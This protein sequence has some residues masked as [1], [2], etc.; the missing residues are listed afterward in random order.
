MG[1]KK[2]RGNGEGTVYQR[3]DGKW[4]AQVSLGNDPTTVKLKRR[5]FYGDSRPEVVKKM[6]EVLVELEKGIYIE[7]ATI[8]L[9]KWLTDWLESRKPLIAENTWNAYE[10][11]IRIHIAP[12]LGK[13]KLKDLK[14]RDIQKLLNEKLT[15]GRITLKGSKRNAPKKYS[16]N[17]GLSARSVKY[18]YQT[19]N[20]ALRQA[21]RERV[22]PFNPAEHC[23]LLRQQKKEMRVFT[24]EELAIF[25]KT[26]QEISPHFTAFYLNVTT[27]LRRGE[28]LGITWDCVD[29]KEG[30]IDVKQ[31]VTVSKENGPVLTG[32][33]TEKSRRKIKLDTDT[34]GLL[35]FH[36]RRQENIKKMLGPDYQDN[37]LVFATDD[38]RPINPR[39]FT[40]HFS[41]VLGKSGLSG[42]RLHDL[43]HLYATLALEAGVDLKTVSSNLGH[44][45]INITADVYGHV[46]EKMRD[47]AAEKVGAAV[48]SCI[49]K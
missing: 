5:T 4:V 33:K 38:G 34:L 48:A 30:I 31:Q 9:E 17:K 11:M 14:T 49:K 40:K 45:S 32:L 41:W 29:F 16:D 35:K 24:L 21:V 39:T 3:K 27:G 10:S 37:N 47:S 20:A 46:T 25:F 2:E 19:L 43:R 36:K 44:T 18:I 28:L 7:P 12:A 26:A 22:I 42:I 8:T 23:E 15:K 1:K 13:V 6:N